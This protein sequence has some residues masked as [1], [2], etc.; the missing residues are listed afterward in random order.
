V[1][2]NLYHMKIA[3]F[4]SLLL[5]TTA[6]FAQETIIRDTINLRGY[7]Y[8]SDGK[9]AKY[10]YLESSYRQI[11]YSGYKNLKLSARTDT[12]G[13]FE[14]NGAC[15]YDTLTLRSH[16]L[17]NIGP[18][19][20][21]GS[22]YMVIYLP[23]RIVDITANNPI[24]ITVKRRHPKPKA[25]Y[26]PEAFNGCILFSEVYLLPSP[27]G[28][29]NRRIS[30]ADYADSIRAH[31]KYPSNAIAHNI[32]GTVKI[33]FTVEKDESLSNFKILQGIGYG[34]DEEVINTIKHTLKWE[35]GINNGR[36]FAMDETI[37]VEFKLTDK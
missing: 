27:I 33:V 19:Y 34:C 28:K 14:L 36:A 8:Q 15:P 21:K 32:E 1:S 7:I 20:N 17:Y 26:H 9:P 6:A 30:F 5:L 37:S 2:I 18:Y 35:P 16:E 10:A 13:Y 23:S 24:I 12:N 3:L 29:K 4:C 11:D 31:I 25:I 22:R